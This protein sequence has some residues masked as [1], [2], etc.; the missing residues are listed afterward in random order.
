MMKGMV[1][2]HCQE[3]LAHA[4]EPSGV[5]RVFPNLSLHSYLPTQEPQNA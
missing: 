4:P 2:S 3:S 1:T 5:R